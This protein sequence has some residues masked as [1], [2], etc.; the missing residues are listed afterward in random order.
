MA[1]KK[2]V[3]VVSNHQ[4]AEQ[5]KHN[6]SARAER[7]KNLTKINRKARQSYA[8]LTPAEK[9][10]HGAHQA[11]LRAMRHGATD[12]EAEKIARAFKRRAKHRNAG[13]HA[14][15]QRHAAVAAQREVRAN[16]KHKGEQMRESFHSALEKIDKNKRMKPAAKVKAKKELRQKYAAERAALAAERKAAMRS[17]KRTLSAIKKKVGPRLK[18]M[19]SNY[20]AAPLSARGKKLKTVTEEKKPEAKPASGKKGRKTGASKNAA[21]PEWKGTRKSKA[22]REWEKMTGKKAV[23]SVPSPLRPAITKEQAEALHHKP[24]AKKRGRPAGSKNKPKT[25]AVKAPVKHPDEPVR[26]RGTGKKTGGAKKKGKA[27]PT[28]R[29]NKRATLD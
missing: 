29:G 15:A 13:E 8:T 12:A 19:I 21:Q 3:E 17:H 27:A 20:H 23:S 25:E 22:V 16:L 28:K 10:E 6:K 2:K 26:E 5:R 11:Y 14:T 4:S 24:A 7:K 1:A 18:D 9:L